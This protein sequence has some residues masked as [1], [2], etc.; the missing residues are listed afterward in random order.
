MPRQV[1]QLNYLRIAPRKVRSVA[2]LIK[3]LPVNEA[4]AQLL[5]QP[6]RAAQPILKL[7]RSAV[8]NAK[9]NQRLS[10]E[11]LYVES[12]R[13]DGGPM[14]KRILPRARGMATPI[15]KKMSHVTLTLM[16]DVNLKQP[17]FT[18]VV[19]KKVKLPKEGKEGS[20][21]KEKSAKE[22]SHAISEAKR[23]GFFK[24]IF[25]RKTGAGA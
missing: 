13:V 25:T 2:E 9:N 8:A 6:R 5:L 20:P 21:K 18:V 12:I 22:K 1:A 16:E 15:H 11:K 23:P 24:R 10:P 17:R 4:E 3:G 19:E 14:L 7:L